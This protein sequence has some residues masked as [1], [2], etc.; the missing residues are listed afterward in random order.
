MDIALREEEKND[1]SGELKNTSTILF[2][3]KSFLFFFVN[4]QFYIL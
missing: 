3:I 4:R 2:Y 1:L